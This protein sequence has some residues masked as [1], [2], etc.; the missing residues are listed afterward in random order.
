MNDSQHANS[1]L[2][3]NVKHNVGTDSEL[4]QSGKKILSSLSH[5]WL[6]GVAQAVT[7]NSCSKFPCRVRPMLIECDLFGNLA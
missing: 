6:L 4:P 3:R 5:E 2:R 7:A 1:G